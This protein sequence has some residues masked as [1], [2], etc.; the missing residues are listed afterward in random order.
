MA[1]NAGHTGVVTGFEWLA[2][3]KCVVAGTSLG[4]GACQ[5]WADADANTTH[6]VGLSGIVPVSHLLVQTC[7]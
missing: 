5:V 1:T 6:P 4:G 7:E 2:G 3:E